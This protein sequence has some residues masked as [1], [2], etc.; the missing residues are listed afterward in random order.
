MIRH[1][2]NNNNNEAIIYLRLIGFEWVATLTQDAEVA[3]I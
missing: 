2:E 1:A 3:A